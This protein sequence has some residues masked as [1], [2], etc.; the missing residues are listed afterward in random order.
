M[1]FDGVAGGLLVHLPAKDGAVCRGKSASGIK[2]LM[3]DT[4][5]PAREQDAEKA[6]RKSGK[7]D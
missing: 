1:V 4:D 7:E 2:L 6:E 3:Q 5:R